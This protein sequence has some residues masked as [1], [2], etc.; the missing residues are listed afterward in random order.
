M[1]L[2]SAITM[3]NTNPVPPGL[4]ILVCIPSYN[5]AKT[6]GDVIQKAKKYARY[7]IV[8]DDGSTDDTYE[9]VR[10]SGAN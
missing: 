4:N 9:I 8:Y 7:V 2:Y 1:R 6:I 10:S 3:S 5:E